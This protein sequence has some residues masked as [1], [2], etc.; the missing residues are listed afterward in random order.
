[1][2][3]CQR[4]KLQQKAIIYPMQKSCSFSGLQKTWRFDHTVYVNLTILLVNQPV[5]C[6]HCLAFHTMTLIIHIGGKG[7]LS[8]MRG[9]IDSQ[10]IVISL[11]LLFLYFWLSY[12]LLLK[13]LNFTCSFFPWIMRK[14]IRLVFSSLSTVIK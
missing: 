8:I 5:S 13:F 4:H 10:E 1:M 14:I 2:D 9:A 6:V 7:I 11:L 3:L 12:F